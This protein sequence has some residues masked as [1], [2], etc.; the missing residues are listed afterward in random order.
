[1]RNGMEGSPIEASPRN[2]S[3]MILKYAPMDEHFNQNRIRQRVEIVSR[4]N[5]EKDKNLRLF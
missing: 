4:I 1:M 3:V 5:K 2:V